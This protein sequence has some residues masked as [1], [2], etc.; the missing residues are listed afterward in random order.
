[1]LRAEGGAHGKGTAELAEVVGV[2]LIILRLFSFGGI[3]IRVKDALF[4]AV[5][6]AGA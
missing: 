5:G 3:G 2:E 4:E 1:M 6:S